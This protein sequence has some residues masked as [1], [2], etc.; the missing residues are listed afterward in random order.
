V[1][2]FYLRSGIRVRPVLPVSE[3]VPAEL[4]EGGLYPLDALLGRASLNEALRLHAEYHG[5]GGG[6]VQCLLGPYAPDF[7]SADTLVRV[8]EE[9]AARG[10]GIQMHTAQGSRETEQML[11]RHGRRTIPFLASLGYFDLDFTAVH[12]TDALPEEIC[13]VAESGSALVVC[14]TAIGL[15]DGRIAPCSPI[16]AAGGRVGLGTDQ[17]AG[18]NNCNLFGEMK[19]T[20]LFG[21]LSAGDPTALPADQVLRM[22]TIEGARVLGLAKE[23]GSLAAGKKADLVFVDTR[24]PTLQ[25]LMLEPFNLAANLVYGARGDE[26][27][28]VMIDGRMVYD[29]GE[30][31]TGA[32]GWR[33]FEGRNR[34]HV[35][36]GLSRAGPGHPALGRRERRGSRPARRPHE[37]SH[38]EPGQRFRRSGS[39][40]RSEPVSIL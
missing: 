36:G 7:V 3:V 30:L 33:C 8:K 18:N 23:V 38:P 20:A 39:V 1:F 14:S 17:A 35:S 22:A 31:R 2:D 19:I 37:F 10:L 4:R 25:P 24:R 11:R 9:A 12:L 13:Q 26:V 28:R 16:R 15:V 40:S 32:T 29:D 21:K 27:A 34:P 5:A 6:R